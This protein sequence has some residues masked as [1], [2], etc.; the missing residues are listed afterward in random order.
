MLAAVEFSVVIVFA[1]CEGVERFQLSCTLN[2]ETLAFYIVWRNSPAFF[3]A[4]KVRTISTANP[5]LKIVCIQ[6]EFIAVCIKHSFPVLL[7]KIVCF[8]L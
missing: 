2:R 3:A 8:V 5:N 1:G 7:Q 4:V 6:C